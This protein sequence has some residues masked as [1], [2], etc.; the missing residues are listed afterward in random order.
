MDTMGADCEQVRKLVVE[1]AVEELG[2]REMRRSDEE[3]RP[4]MACLAKSGISDTAAVEVTPFEGA[5]L[6]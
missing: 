6:A 3:G 4:C 2:P 1:Q 5:I